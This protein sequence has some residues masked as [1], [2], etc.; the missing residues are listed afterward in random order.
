MTPWTSLHQIIWVRKYYT[1]IV[2][3]KKKISIYA[4][5]IFIRL[6]FNMWLW[7]LFT[8]PNSFFK[9]EFYAE[10]Y[11]LNIFAFLLFTCQT[12]CEYAIKSSALWLYQQYKNGV[13]ELIEAWTFLFC[14]RTP[15]TLYVMWSIHAHHF[16][17]TIYSD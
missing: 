13:F 8:C 14:Y 7:H 2:K 11:F 3:I 10:K 12:C 16:A 15:Q 17:S 4:F 1:F 5:G 9:R 6:E